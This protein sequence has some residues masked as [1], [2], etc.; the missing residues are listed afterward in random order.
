MTPV[1]VV[2]PAGIDRDVALRVY[3]V[4]STGKSYSKS[5]FQAAESVGVMVVDVTDAPVPQAAVFVP[6]VLSQM[7]A[8]PN[9]QVIVGAVNSSSGSV[10]TCSTG[11]WLA[12]PKSQA[13][14]AP[15]TQSMFTFQLA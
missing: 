15:D 4:A 9:A 3:F 11:Y 12:V 14:S 13:S 2:D 1:T 10:R 5:V 7:V 8:L 6:A